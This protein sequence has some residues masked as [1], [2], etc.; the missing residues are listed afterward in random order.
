MHRNI[1]RSVVVVAIALAVVGAR[2]DDPPAR[3]YA[4]HAAAL[5]EKLGPGFAVLV[6]EPFIVIGDEPL[7]GVQRHAEQTVRWATRLLKAQYFEHDPPRIIDIY[8][9]K[10][11][12]SY[13]HHAKAL[14]GDE[15]T[16]PYGY[17]SA[18]RGVMVMNIGTGGGTLVHEMVHAFMAGNF[19]RCPAWVNEGLGS[20]YEQCRERDGRIEGLPNWRL[21][22]LQ[23]TIEAGGLPT[24]EA[25]CRTTSAE[26]YGDN[27]GTH[28][29]M[30]RYLMLY[31][32]SRGKLEAFYRAAVA[33]HDADPACFAAL[34][35]TL[36]DDGSDMAAFQ[37]RWEAWVLKL[38]FGG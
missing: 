12:D 8:L 24:L 23:K 11:G 14:F 27:A 9:F 16:T 22:A 26:F 38:R 29:A 18:R 37:R 13:R 35:D 1:T 7:D 36:G 4:G 19:P 25:L 21:P 28:Y 5:R 30:A 32:Q 6:E 20:L 17:Y 33:G 10:D 31:L 3:D 34:V 2:A 15:P